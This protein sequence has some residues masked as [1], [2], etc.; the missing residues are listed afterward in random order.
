M[1]GW[2]GETFQHEGMSLTFT[3]ELLLNFGT[4][5]FI[6][7]LCHGELVRL[8]PDPRHLTEFYLM[9]SA[10]GA[11]GGVAVSLAAP[12]LFK[13]YLEWNIGMLVAYAMAVVVLFLAVPKVGRRRPAALLVFGFSLGGFAAV[14]LWQVKLGPQAATDARLVDR[15]RNFYGVVSV[16]KFADPDHPDEDRLRMKHGAIWHGQQ[17][18]S[19]EKRRLPMTYYPAESGVGRAMLEL[20]KRCYHL[21]VGLVGLGVGSLAS[22]A[23]PGDRFSFYEINPV[24]LEMAEKHFTYLADARDREATIDVMMG[25]ARL[26]LERQTPQKFDL[27]VLDAFSGDS[28]PVHLLTRE[29]MDIYRRHVAADGVIAIHIT[30]SYLNLFPVVRALAE[31]AHLGWRRVAMPD[32]GF[33]LRNDWVA[34]SGRAAFLEAIPNI[35]PPSAQQDA[36]TIPAWTDQDNNQ[37]RILVGR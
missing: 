36:F 7:M 33:R 5:F 15:Q 24:V 34:I 17:F 31:N 18:L 21:H 14:L 16:W 2:V 4:M 20:Q 28:V 26:S 29:A 10:G 23:R 22:Y 25:D 9:L 35:P 13:T 6:C 8:R 27:L 3:Q 19:P 30:N 1:L 37:F 12:H 32:E 11:L